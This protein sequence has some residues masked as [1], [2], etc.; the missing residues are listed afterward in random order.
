MRI[1][2]FTKTPTSP[3]PSLVRRGTVSPLTKG[4]GATRPVSELEVDSLSKLQRKM[5]EKQRGSRLI[6]DF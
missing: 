1:L 4:V 3:N 5:E 6:W 2:D